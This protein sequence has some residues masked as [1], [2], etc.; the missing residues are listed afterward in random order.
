MTFYQ[1]G[2]T[3]TPVACV[4]QTNA[5]GMPVSVTAGPNNTAT[6]TSTSFTP[7]GGGWGCFAGYYSGDGNYSASSAT[8]TA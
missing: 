2:P 4:S 8:S 1:C 7:T 3:A 5:I 6:A